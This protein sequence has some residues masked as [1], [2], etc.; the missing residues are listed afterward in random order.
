[1]SN[2]MSL[3]VIAAIVCAAAASGAVFMPGP[4]YEA[5][6]K[7]WWTPPNWLFP[8]AWT[9]LYAMIA[10]AGWFVWK[11]GGLN[12][13]IVIWCAGL[14]VNAL[15]SYLMFGKHDIWLAL[16]DVSALWLAVLAFIIVAWPVDSRAAYLFMP[17]LAW[18][19]FAAALNYEVWRLNPGG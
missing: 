5:L 9:I 16:V 18:V 8:I 6:S 11:A 1:M 15:W 7:P 19:S 3:I 4:W 14:V 13:A 2:W 10:L 17:Y 12:T